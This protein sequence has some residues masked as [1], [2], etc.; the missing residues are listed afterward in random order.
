MSVRTVAGRHLVE[1]QLRGIRVHRHCPRGVTRAEAEA[2]EAKLRH[3]IF[4]A[5]D[6]GVDPEIPLP[7]AIQTWLD[8]RVAGSKSERSRQLHAIALARF[9]ISKNLRDI[10]AVADEYRKVKG[11]KPATINRRLSVLKAVA[12]FAWRKEWT[13]DNLSARVWLLPENNAR[14]EYLEPAEVRQL[15]AQA[16]T[17][18]GKAWIALAAYT[19][20]RRGELHA[21]RKDQVKRGVVYLGTSKNGEPRLVPIARPALPYV[22]EIPFTRTVDSLDWEFRA[23]RA[24]A[25]F[26]HIRFHDLRHTTASFLANTGSDLHTIG[27]LLGHKST[28]TTRRYSH[29]AMRT[30]KAA[31]G[32]MK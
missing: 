32:R 9:V 18:A 4:A 27:R 15:I 16:L 13:R 12:K 14:H 11:L 5:R 20:L 3:E 6:L 1:F 19:G 25:G 8:E 2:L 10:P 22:S 21:L 29:L 26:G 30:L 17:P 28:V 24:A 23:A 7:G 31:V